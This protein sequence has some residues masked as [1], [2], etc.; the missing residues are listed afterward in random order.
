MNEHSGTFLLGLLNSANVPTCFLTFCIL[1]KGLSIYCPGI[2]FAIAEVPEHFQ[3]L[4][5]G[6]CIL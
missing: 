4:S 2:E 3:K 6:T 5:K 1:K